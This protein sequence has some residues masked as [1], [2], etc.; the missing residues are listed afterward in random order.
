MEYIQANY[1]LK[2]HE[3]DT[4][5]T[6]VQQHCFQNCGTVTGSGFDAERKTFEE[7]SLKNT[8]TS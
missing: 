4:I 8:L 3:N 6:T 7:G 2:P 1:L 5:I